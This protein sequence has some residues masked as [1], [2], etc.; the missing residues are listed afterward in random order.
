MKDTAPP[1]LN[2]SAAVI[3]IIGALVYRHVHGEQRV[4]SLKMNNS[5]S[6]SV[7]TNPWGPWAIFWVT[8]SVG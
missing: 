3:D 1:P 6:L 8:S 2:E 7:E 4:C 5:Q